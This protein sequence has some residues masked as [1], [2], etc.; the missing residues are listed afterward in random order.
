[1][2]MQSEDASGL[3]TGPIVVGAILLALGTAMLLNSTGVID[4]HLGRFIGPLVL[5][6]IGSSIVL[7]QH[8]LVID[9]RESTADGDRRRRRRRRRGST[10]GIYLIGLGIWLLVSQNHVFGL[11]FATSWPLLIILSGFMIVIRGMR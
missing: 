6:A 10:G 9:S 5:I 4:V 3:R 2:D 7:G 1:M 11:T 8:G